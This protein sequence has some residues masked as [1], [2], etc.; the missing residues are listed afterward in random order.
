[1]NAC[2]GYCLFFGST[3]FWQF[4]DGGHRY[5]NKTLIFGCI[6]DDFTGAS[7]A[8][9][10]LVKGGL[11]TVLCNGIPDSDF[12]PGD[13]VQAVVIALKSRTVEVEE[14]V[15][16]SLNALKWLKD[17]GTQQVYFKYCSTFDSTPRGNIGPVTDALMEAVQ[18]KCTILCPALPVNKRTIVDGCLLVDGV[19][20]QE[21]SMS[22]HPLT[23][24]WDCRI[25]N[26]MKQQGQFETLEIHRDTL[27]PVS[28]THLRAH[29]TR[30]DLVCR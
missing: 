25:A 6:A 7:D 5:M 22:K 14:A 26:L 8:A 2:A 16:D 27:Y 3:H 15:S 9:S 24:M 17:H 4:V 12:D 10:F 11:N 19:P 13:N 29:E 21:S 18:T 1:M 30:H 20:L 28:Y 23:P